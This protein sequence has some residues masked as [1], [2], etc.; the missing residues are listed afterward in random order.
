MIVQR[1][2]CFQCLF[3]FFLRNKYSVFV[4]TIGPGSLKAL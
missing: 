1:G 3:D 2:Y 4:W